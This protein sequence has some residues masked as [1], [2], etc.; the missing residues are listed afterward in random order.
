MKGTRRP[1]VRLL[2][3]ANPEDLLNTAEFHSGSGILL[4]GVMKLRTE[5]VS[6]E[7]R[8]PAA[9]IH[10]TSLKPQ[11]LRHVSVVA[12]FSPATTE[13]FPIIARQ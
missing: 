3:S 7:F 1:E 8:G 4:L 2:R 5:E 9:A 6:G 11:F 10:A 12:G 13:L